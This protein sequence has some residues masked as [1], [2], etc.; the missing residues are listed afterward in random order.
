VRWWSWMATAMD[1]FHQPPPPPIRKRA[2]TSPS[3]LSTTPPD[4]FRH[5]PLQTTPSTYRYHLPPSHLS[6]TPPDRFR[7]HPLQTTPST[8]RYHLPP[9]PSIFT[10]LS[11]SS[12]VHAYIRMLLRMT[13][14]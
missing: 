12:D 9:S 7:H 3:H 14:M 11:F 10:G 8:Y 2:Q 6:T 1:F 4:R 13:P 5:H